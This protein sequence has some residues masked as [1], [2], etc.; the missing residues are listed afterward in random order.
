MELWERVVRMV[1]VGNGKIPARVYDA[2]VVGGG[3]AGLS[4]ATWLA[5]YR[6]SVLVVDS[7]EYRN[8][9][10]ARSHGYLGSDP[11]D[12]MALLA[13]ARAQLSRY[14]GVMFCDGAATTA[15]RDERGRFVVGVGNQ[16]VV[17]LRMVLATGVVD[18]F[19]DVDGFFD[20]YGVSVFHCPT[21]DGYEA[22][23]RTVVVFGWSESVTGFALE[24]LDW[25]GHL[26][27]LTQGR[28]YEG[29][30]VLGAS[31]SSTASSCSRTMRSSWSAS[32]GG[33]GRSGCAAGPASRRIWRSSP[34]PTTP[35]CTWPSNSDAN[36]PKTAAYWSTAM[37][38]PPSRASTARETSRRASSSSRSPS[39]QARPQGWPAQHHFKDSGEHPAHRLRL[40]IPKPG[41]AREIGI[42]RNAALRRRPA[43]GGGPG[44]CA[45]AGIRR[46]VRTVRGESARYPRR[47]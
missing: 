26:T 42:Q 23:E 41:C 13:G 8:R 20:H 33:C 1:A 27:I 5:R 40:P 30:A 39:E 44:W 31:S 18:Q 14:P 36:S 12:P 34:S 21:C 32:P 46:A 25:A 6:R 22:K 37:V 2:V 28:R 45:V 35:E 10:A 19:P 16:E 29:D 43:R 24:L 3:P 4:A 9:W 47:P 15:R 38:R 11:A 7:R 17:A